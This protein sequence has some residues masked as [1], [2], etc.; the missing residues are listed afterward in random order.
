[1]VAPS[2]VERRRKVER[3][4]GY[5]PDAG[6]EVEAPP[7]GPW[8]ARSGE[9]VA[10]DESTVNAK[11]FLDAIVM[12]HAQRNR[13][14]ADPSGTNE[15]DGSQVFSETD[16]LV[17]QIIAPITGPWRRRWRLPMYAKCKHQPLN[18][19]GVEVGIANPG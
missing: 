13:C 3:V 11:P 16:D 10:T 1:M 7:D 15:S 9:L 19:R 18:Q 12:E 5:D 4:Y 6:N 8:G 2:H 17:D 14:L